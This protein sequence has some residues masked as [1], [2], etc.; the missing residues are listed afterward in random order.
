MIRS[1]GAAALIAVLAASAFP[2]SAHSHHHHRSPAAVPAAAASGAPGSV[3]SGCDDAG[4]QQ[5]RAQQKSPWEV[6]VCGNV[7]RVPPSR[8]TRSGPHEYF[9][10]D[11]PGGAPIEVVSNENELGGYFPVKVGDSA[12]VRGRYY[13]D[14]NGT[15]GIDWT[16]H[17]TSSTWRFSG[18]VV[19][20]G[21][22]YQ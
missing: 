3:A 10:I 13:H 15:E 17:G 9:F 2:A 5:I 18:Y 22:K 7:I 11:I 4:F 1:A 8:T 12:L 6:T 20:N 19:I 16:H 21:R 14:P